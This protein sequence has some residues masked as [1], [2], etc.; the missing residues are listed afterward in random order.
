MKK[1]LEELTEEMG[2]AFAAAGY[3]KDL[4]KVTL[5]NRP[6]LCEFQCNGAM[7]GARSYKKAPIMIANDVAVKL[8]DSQVFG[9]VEA[10]APGFL[11]LKVSDS[12]LL[13][14]LEEMEA[15]PKFGLNMPVSPKKII[16]D[17]G[18]PNVAKP[19][20]VGHLR[21]AVI[22]ESVKRIC[23]YVGHE[24]IGDVHLGD[25]GL[26]MGLNIIGLQDR[27]PDLVYFDESYEGEYPKE[28]PFTIS[29]LE[30]IYPAASAK[31]KEDPEYKA[32]AMEATVKLQ[33]GV[34]GHRALW[35]HILNVSVADLKKNYA[36][37]NVEFDLWKG[38]SNVQELIPDMVAY[39]KEEGYAHESEG[40]LVVDVK[41]ETDT[42]EIPPCMILKS[43][44]A[45]LYNTTDLATILE[46]MNLYQPD[47]IIYV[48][49]KRQELYFEQ[50]FRC[51]RKTK[52][53]KPGTELKFLGFGTMNGKDG[54][55]FKTREGGVMRLEDLIRDTQEEMY[56]KI[57]EGR[58]KGHEISDEEAGL[59]AETVAV[60][61]LKYGDLSNQASKDYVFDLDRFTSFE[62]DTGPYILYTIT[63]IK[64]ILAKYKGQ[65]GNLAQVT[66]REP[67]NESEKAL[68]LQL[69]QFQSMMA[70]ACEELAPHKVCSYIYDLSNAFNHF[71]HE[72][73]ILREEDQEKR[74]GLIALLV[75]TRDVLETCID[76]LGFG[77]PERM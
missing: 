72:T 14:Y 64:S 35:R 63:R 11:N 42:K 7:A 65:G 60:S 1:L 26:Q 50:V 32:R 16:I 6:D 31:S 57:L 71:Y 5:S 25:W 45:S 37:L 66:L 40:A 77:A 38:E 28:A 22:G 9:A 13:H 18:G 24:V 15:D 44:G 41:E 49:D 67:Q 34:R 52:L 70:A 21:S 36:K 73:N 75:L 48:V 33:N 30:E 29:E 12:F 23:R 20:H 47:E 56:R 4:G 58:E 54:K 27:Q 39:M 17:Y 76:V 8:A 51:A 2:Q 53:V 68:M 46:R 74:S 59:V 62:G 61:A 19:L 69:T 3:D 55:P 43:D 10:V